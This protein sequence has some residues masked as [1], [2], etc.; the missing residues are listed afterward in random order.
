LVVATPLAVWADGF[1]W[2]PAAAPNQQ[3]S[4]VPKSSVQKDDSNLTVVQADS[5][6]D[7]PIV[8]VVNKPKS[9]KSS[10][11]WTK[12]WHPTQWFSSSKKK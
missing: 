9:K 5:A 7:Q 2:S 8:E 3:I 6:Q 4:S 1:G 12:V 11:F 10:S